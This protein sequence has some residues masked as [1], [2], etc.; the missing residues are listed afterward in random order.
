MESGG[1]LS[2]P[3]RSAIPATATA[4]L[5]VRMV[6]D[7]VPETQNAL[8]AEHVRTPGLLRRRPA[9]I[10]PTEERRTH[11]DDRPRR[12]ARPRLGGLAG[13]D[14]RPL[15]AGR[16]H[17]A[18][19]RRRAAGAAADARRQPAVR[20]LQ[21]SLQMPT[22]GRLDRQLRQQ[23][24]RPGRE[25]APAEPVGG[26]R[27]AGQPDDDAGRSDDAR[28]VGRSGGSRWSLGQVASSP[29]QAPA[30]AATAPA[31]PARAQLAAKLQAELERL[32]DAAPGRGRRRRGRPHQRRALGRQRRRW[33]SRRAARSRSRCSSSCSAAP[34]PAS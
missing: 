20:H 32:A 12:S 34:T 18:D 30:P 22:V 10:R 27:D 29:A 19:P 33:S 4:R 8:I 16:G 28:D 1:G 14:G 6:K 5:E 21:R 31:R 13:V 26:H 9:A 3:G 23:P 7:L 2:I 11:A 15:V 17:G 25:P 24:A